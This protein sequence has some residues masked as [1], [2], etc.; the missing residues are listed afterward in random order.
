MESFP[1]LRLPPELVEQIFTDCLPPKPSFYAR[2]APLLLTHV[3]RAWREVALN[4]A[5]LWTKFVVPGWQES[6]PGI[7]ELVSLWL[8]RASEVPLD[9]EISMFDTDVQVIPPDDTLKKWKEKLE[10][11]VGSLAPYHMQ[12]H[13][14]SGVFPDDLMAKVGISEMRNVQNIFYCGMLGSD[15][16]FLN[17]DESDVELVDESVPSVLDVGPA[18]ETLQRFAVVGCAVNME[19]IKL[20]K[21]LTQLELTD[22]H[23]GG[24]LCEENALDL[25]I[26][27]PSLK[28]AV[29]DIT[30]YERLEFNGTTKRIELPNLELFF[31]TW[32][33]PADVSL[34]LDSICTPNLVNLGLRGTAVAMPT[35]DW[36]SLHNFLEASHAPIKRIS[37]GDFAN[38][39]MRLLDCLGFCPQLEHLTINHTT[40]SD[41]FFRALTCNDEVWDTHLLPCLQIL[42]L[43]VCEGFQRE[44]LVQFLQS[45]STD[46]PSGFSTLNECAIMFCPSVLTEHREELE[47]CGVEN[48]ILETMDRE[49]QGPYA[50]VVESHRELL[51]IMYQDEEE[52]GEWEESADGGDDEGGDGIDAPHAEDQEAPAGDEMVPERIG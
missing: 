1:L 9:V 4:C 3:C 35:H 6:P 37:F 45:R 36:N 32:Q 43:G 20:Q 21:Q 14:L 12:I 8:S 41:D 10:R 13:R 11:I 51:A 46:V 16:A 52:V 33:F 47:A 40:I 42:N 5:P 22:L 34:L 44:S 31:V 38:V 18:R 26:N 39:R 28:I 2:D 27:L 15:F 23:R 7:D 29:L 25:L 24:D 50:R 19:C 48:L 49:T 30:R 17:N